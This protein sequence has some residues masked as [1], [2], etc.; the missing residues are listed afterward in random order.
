MKMVQFN[1]GNTQLILYTVFETD[2][3]GFTFLINQ[4]LAWV[5]IEK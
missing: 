1:G 4:P 3:N 2:L 5:D